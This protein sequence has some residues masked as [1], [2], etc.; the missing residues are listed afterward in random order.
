MMARQKSRFSVTTTSTN[1]YV[2]VDFPSEFIP[3]DSPKY[4]PLPSEAS[5]WQTVRGGDRQ[6]CLNVPPLDRPRRLLRKRTNTPPTPSP[7]P[8]EPKPASPQSVLARKRFNHGKADVPPASPSSS[9]ARRLWPPRPPTPPPSPSLP[10]TLKRK[11]SHARAKMMD[12]LGQVVGKNDE[13][14]WVCVDVEQRVVHRVA[15]IV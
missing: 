10:K 11:A 7:S 15:H 2:E 1:R 13:D 5:S 6:F 9:R 4:A 14:G 12:R 3:Y 8:V